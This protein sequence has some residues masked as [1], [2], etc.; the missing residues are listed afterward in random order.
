MDNDTEIEEQR[1][2]VLDEKSKA[3]K[4]M[5]VHQEDLK[6]KAF[7]RVQEMEA[8]CYSRGRNCDRGTYDAP[9]R[10]KPTQPLG[11]NRAG[12]RRPLDLLR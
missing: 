4:R 7:K 8:D 11:R 10:R 9:P 3:F 6:P 5:R 1:Q 2:R 12:L